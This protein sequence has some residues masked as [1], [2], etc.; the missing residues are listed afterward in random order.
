MG[1]SVHLGRMSIV[2]VETGQR[3]R[4]RGRLMHYK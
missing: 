3:S 2:E 1:D 4:E